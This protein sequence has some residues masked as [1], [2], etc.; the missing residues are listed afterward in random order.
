MW[1][2]F[3][4]MLRNILTILKNGDFSCYEIDNVR[5]I[6]TLRISDKSSARR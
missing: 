6:Q 5:L 3:K 4:K 1:N 2:S